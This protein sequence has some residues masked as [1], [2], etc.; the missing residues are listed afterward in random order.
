MKTNYYKMQLDK[1]NK[2]SQVDIKLTDF[3]GNQTNFMV[4]NSESIKE[5][6]AFLDELEQQQQ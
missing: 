4:L 1:I 2:L 6:R 3:N 5:L